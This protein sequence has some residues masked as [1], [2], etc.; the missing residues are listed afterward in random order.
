MSQ[1]GMPKRD[2]PYDCMPKYRTALYLGNK[3]QPK[4]ESKMAC[5]VIDMDLS[6]LG[7]TQLTCNQ[8]AQA[9]CG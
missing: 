1:D 5:L 8:T 6:H 7:L 9:G 3:N 2:M 4:L